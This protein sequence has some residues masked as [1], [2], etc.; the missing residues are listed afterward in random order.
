MIVAGLMIG[1]QVA[2]KAVRDSGFLSAWPATAL[3]AMVFATA[4]VVVAAVPIYSWLLSRFSPRV[5]VP[6]GFLLIVL[7]HENHSH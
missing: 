7:P 6:V 1:H 3:P 2:A 5:V 4:I